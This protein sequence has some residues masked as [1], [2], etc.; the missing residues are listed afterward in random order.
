MGQIYKS[1]GIM[2]VFGVEYPT[3]GEYN[4]HV[5]ASGEVS[6]HEV[7]E[8]GLKKLRAVPLNRF[9][10]GGCQHYQPFV[11]QYGI[12]SSPLTWLQ[13]DA[14]ESGEM[15]S[16][17]VTALSGVPIRPLEFGGR[18][19]GT[20]Y[21]DPYAEYIRLGGLLPSDLSASREEQARSLFENMRN[22]LHVNG[23]CFTNTVRTWL[24]LDQLLDWY[25]EFNAVRTR[26]FHGEGIFD[27]VIPA[28]TGIGA[29]N[30]H[31]AAIIADLLAVRPKCRDVKIF[32]VDSPLQNA[33]TEYRSS[34]SRAVEV[35]LPTH[36]TLYISGTASIDKNGRTVYADSSEKQMALTMEVVSGLLSSRG[37]TWEDVSRGIAYFKSSRDVPLLNKYF[38][39]KGIGRFPLSISHADICRRDLLFEIEIDAVKPT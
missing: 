21:E 20:A 23:M 35:D 10:M 31:G 25:D 15:C 3:R 17:Q 13:G 16:T 14:C 34:F 32:A 28:S 29:S 22:I 18:I 38:W 37:M 19:V 27:S 11:E 6:L 1:S 8:D 30:P 9:V 39:E 12:P 36:R 26:F 7:L 33:A 4:I 2:D 5:E 24:Y